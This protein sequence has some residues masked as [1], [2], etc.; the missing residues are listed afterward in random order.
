MIA[1]ITAM[2][3]EGWALAILAHPFERSPG[4]LD[5]IS[6]LHR[7]VKGALKTRRGRARF[8]FHH[9]NAYV[10]CFRCVRH[11]EGGTC[12]APRLRLWRVR[13][14]LRTGDYFVVPISP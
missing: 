4:Q 10:F 12:R 7:S 3:A 8:G 13:A 5:E 2:P 11:D 1:D 14:R 6:G 9:T